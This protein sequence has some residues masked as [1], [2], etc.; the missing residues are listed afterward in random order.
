VNQKLDYVPLAQLFGRR[1]PPRS[2]RIGLIVFAIVEFA[3][4]AVVGQIRNWIGFV[5]MHC[6]APNRPA[7][8][9]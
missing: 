8:T 7:A 2:V 9:A 4:L 6:V 1:P 3:F 5:R